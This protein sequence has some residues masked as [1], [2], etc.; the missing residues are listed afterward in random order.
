MV[1][2][3]YTLYVTSQYSRATLS[4]YS[5]TSWSRHTACADWVMAV[6]QLTYYVNRI[7]DVELNSNSSLTVSTTYTSVL[8]YSIHCSIHYIMSLID[9]HS[10][11]TLRVMLRCSCSCWEWLYILR[12]VHSDS[13]H[14]HGQTSAASTVICLICLTSWAGILTSQASSS[15]ERSRDRKILQK[16]VPRVN[17][18]S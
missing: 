15:S 2:L 7:Y 18:R 14:S 10:C 5:V 9:L 6:G 1:D 12:R 13:G 17:G 8:T 4:L 11:T 3:V 16:G